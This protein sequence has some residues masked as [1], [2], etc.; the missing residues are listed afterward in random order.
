MVCQHELQGQQGE[1]QP[2]LAAQLPVKES[3]VLVWQYIYIIIL[4]QFFEKKLM[5][6]TI[7]I[8]LHTHKTLPRPTPRHTAEQERCEVPPEL[9]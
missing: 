3:L 1:T 4:F 5:H 6:R 8:F 2:I 9:H 7:V